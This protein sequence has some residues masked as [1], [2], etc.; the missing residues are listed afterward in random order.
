[1]RRRAVRTLPNFEMR[2][3]LRTQTQILEL[4]NGWARGNELVRAAVLTSSRANPKCGTDLL[5]DYDIE[6]FVTDLEPFRQSDA[7]LT[8]FGGVMARWP[9]KPR[10]GAARAGITRLVIFSDAVR[11]DFQIHKVAEVAPDTFDDGYR[12]LLDKDGLLSSLSPPSYGKHLVKKPT[13]GQYETLVNEFWWNA[14]YVPKYLRRD[15]LPFAAS[16]LEKSIRFKYLHTVIEWFIGSQHDWSVNT[17][18]CGRKFKRYL[19]GQTWAEYESTFAGPGLE[20]QWHAFCNGVNLFRR[21]AKSVGGR[22]GYQYPETIDQNM[23]KYFQWI[24]TTELG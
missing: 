24:W 23:S 20:D 7:W 18:V 6:F 3:Q 9:F 14:H 11:I 16:M 13:R 2:S 12:V 10:A 5:S 4:F 15:E 19:D 22:L 17:G 1:M 21:L 8:H